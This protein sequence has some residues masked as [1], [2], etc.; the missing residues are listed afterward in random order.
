MGKND[1]QS[2]IK[3]LAF[4]IL[5]AAMV[6]T[7]MPI[8]VSAYE[9]KSETMMYDDLDFVKSVGLKSSKKQ[10]VLEYIYADYMNGHDVYKGSG[11]CYGYAESIRKLFGTSYTQKKFGVKATKKNVYKKLKKLRP[12]THVR[13]AAKKNGGGRAHSV[14]LLKITK[15]TIWYTDGNVDYYGAIRYAEEPLGSFCE[16]LRGSGRKYL[17]WARAPKGSVPAVKSVKVKANSFFDGPETHISWRPVKKAKNYIVYRS[18]SKESGYVKIAETKKCF[19][20]DSSQDLYGKAY[21]KVK[22]VK[23]GKSATSKPVKALRKLK[24]PVVYMT[25]DNSGDATQLNF[26]WDAVP[27]AAKY[28]IY[29]WS[30]S[31]EQAVLITTVSGTSWQCK[32]NDNSDT[33]Y[34]ITA[35]SKRSGSESFPAWLYY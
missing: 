4:S 11:E 3:K 18:T 20:I 25:I 19:Y 15:N 8:A 16:R 6:V 5:A 32:G 35:E 26:R 22:A 33:E 27:G 10:A 13:F 28:N 34:L 21:Y 1:W 23:S 24:A 30:E 29:K 17:A 7:A 14:V 2:L 12:G 31:K 9:Q